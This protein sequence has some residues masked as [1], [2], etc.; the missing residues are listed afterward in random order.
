[1]DMTASIKAAGI[2]VRFKFW[3]IIFQ[4]FFFDIFEKEIVEDIVKTRIPA[5]WTRD[6]VYER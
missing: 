2:F 1:M 3:E 6:D 4:V 5:D